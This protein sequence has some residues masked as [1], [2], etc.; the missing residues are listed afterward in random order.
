[1]N[2]PNHARLFRK[3]ALEKLS[4]P[5]QLDQ[6]LEITSSKG[7]IALWAVGFCILMAIIWG[8][9]G[10]IPT[11]V[12]AQGIIIKK[13]GVFDVVSMGTGLVDI[14]NVK[15]G[16][17]IEKGSL[18][19]TLQQPEQVNQIKAMNEKINNMTDRYESLKNQTDVKAKKEFFEQKKN[20]IKSTI[21]TL[22]KNLVNSRERVKS[23]KSLLKD[24][25]ITKNQLLTAQSDVD[26]ILQGI[27]SKKNE[28]NQID[29]NKM[30]ISEAR[31]NELKHLSQQLEETRTSIQNMNESL[32]L[33]S[34]IKSTYNGRVVELK[35]KQ[36][37]LVSA[38]LPI[39][40]LEI[41]EKKSTLEAILYIS[42]LDGKKVKKGLDAQIAPTTIKTEEYGY[43]KGVVE[44]VSDYPTTSQQMMMRLQ[45]KELV[46]TLT[47]G[48]A[49][50]EMRISLTPDENAFSGYKWTSPQGPPI[51]VQTGT[52]CTST[53]TVKKQKPISLVIPWFKKKTGLE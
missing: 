38:G 5:D 34:E 16:D 21:E 45:N 40:T 19:A 11:R 32:K 17:I 47:A 39:I 26:N 28:L 35:V 3:K 41:A 30:D 23:Q 31:A 52:M 44:Y 42:P 4:S 36:G 48:G 37:S 14:I 50:F 49:P 25:I 8:V 13:G 7:W 53:I 10:E 24:G 2:N 22:K 12:S 20:L 33:T 6:M 18:I 46:G 15:T 27:E 29:L 43:M 51:M 9:K 1:M